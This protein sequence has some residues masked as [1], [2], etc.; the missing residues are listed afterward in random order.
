MKT[1]LTTNSQEVTHTAVT[2]TELLKTKSELKSD[3]RATRQ[4]ISNLRNTLVYE[5]MRRQMISYAELK[6][7]DTPIS[8]G[9][10]LYVT[11]LPWYKCL[12]RKQKTRFAIG[13]GVTRGKDLKLF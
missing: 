1:T 3:I 6:D 12:F 9:T 11:N 8:E 7:L 2:T 5:Y 13:D 10:F 4:D